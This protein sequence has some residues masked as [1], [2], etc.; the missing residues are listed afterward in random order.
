M[1]PPFRF[2]ETEVCGRCRDGVTNRRLLAFLIDSAIAF[3]VFIGSLFILER[4]DAARFIGEAWMLPA[5]V[6][7]VVAWVLL[8]DAIRGGSP[9][10]RLTG[11]IVLCEETGEPVGVWKSVHRNLWLLKL[12]LS[13]PVKGRRV[14]D[15]S[16]STRVILRRHADSPV[17]AVHDPN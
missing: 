10:K 15:H 2:L 5:S 13:V 17:F 14:S 7:P 1:H 3:G 8:R 9:G 4:T 6:P 12:D 11:L 16:A